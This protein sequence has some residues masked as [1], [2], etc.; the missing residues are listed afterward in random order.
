MPGHTSQVTVV[1]GRIGVL[2]RIQHP[3]EQVD[4]TDESIGL[5][6]VHTT[7]RVVIGQI[8]QDKTG[9]FGIARIQDTGTRMPVLGRHTQPT[10]QG[11]R[12]FVPPHA[13]VRLGGRGPGDAG[14]REFE[15]TQR[16]EK[17]GLAATGSPRQGDHRV[18][19][20]QTQSGT[21]VV[22]KL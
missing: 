21:R 22:Q 1:N 7:H 14:L 18:F 10:Q 19:L 2:L 13:G 20:G 12:A 8:E 11:V 15:P 5:G 17:R 4:R 16:I 6:R 3:H 9:E